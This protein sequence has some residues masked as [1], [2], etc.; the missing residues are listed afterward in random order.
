MEAASTLSPTAAP[1]VTA[2]WMRWTGRVLT[3]LPILGLAMSSM[4]KL[5]HAPPI[6]EQWGPKF[7]YPEGTLTAIGVVELLCAVLYAIPR[8]SVL[9]AILITGYLGGAVAT[10]VR[11]GE[12]FVP[13]LML[14]IFAWAGLFL[15]D[16]RLRELLP[17]RS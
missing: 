5:S 15:R 10:H 2:P 6:L 17:L 9:G 1:T 13:P 3:A 16:R 7:G 14:G 8:T 11:I 4:M 12:M